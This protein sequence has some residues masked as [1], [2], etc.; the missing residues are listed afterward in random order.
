MSTHSAG[1][2]AKTSST[3]PTSTQPA[4]CTSLRCTHPTMSLRVLIRSRSSASSATQT[5]PLHRDIALWLVHIHPT[6]GGREGDGRRTVVPDSTH[7]R[8]DTHFSIASITTSL[9]AGRSPSG[10]RRPEEHQFGIACRLELLAAT[11][12]RDAAEGV[13][14]GGQGRHPEHTQLQAHGE[15]EQSGGEDTEDNRERPSVADQLESV[16]GLSAKVER[17]CAGQFFLPGLS[18]A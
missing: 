16:P 6:R 8:H 2:Q 18:I 9:P 1:S 11:R 7:L 15:R 14:L 3:V 4:V 17:H 13:E 10:A 12:R 5:S